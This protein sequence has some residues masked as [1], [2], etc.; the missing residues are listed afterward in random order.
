[1]NFKVVNSCRELQN[2]SD[3]FV[4]DAD[5][6][7]ANEAIANPTALSPTRSEQELTTDFDIRPS[8]SLTIDISHD[9]AFIS[10]KPH[11]LRR[12]ETRRF[13]R[14]LSERSM[15]ESVCHLK[16]GDTPAPLPDSTDSK[17]HFRDWA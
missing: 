7:G 16:N 10:T 3:M 12:S 6:T 13:I 14:T 5:F 4:L 15:E 9:G 11:R 8:F 1:M 17:A 2:F